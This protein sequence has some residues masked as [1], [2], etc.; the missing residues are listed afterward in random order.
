MHQRRNGTS[1][2]SA[3]LR[4]RIQLQQIEQ[5]VECLVVN[6]FELFSALFFQQRRQHFN[7][8]V[9][10]EQVSQVRVVRQ[11]LDHVQ[12]LEECFG[13]DDVDAQQRFHC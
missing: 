4:Q 1:D 12:Q 13:L 7:V 3:F 11:V 5:A 2:G 8:S 6:H 9:V 10:N